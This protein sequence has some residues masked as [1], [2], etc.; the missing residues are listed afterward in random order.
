MVSVT[1][2][3]QLIISIRY[4]RRVE[5]RAQIIRSNNIPRDAREGPRA[6]PDEQPPPGRRRPDDLQGAHGAAL[7]LLPGQRVDNLA[8]HGPRH[9]VRDVA[10]GVGLSD[11]AARGVKV[12]LVGE[13][14]RR[15][16]DPGQHGEAQQREDALQQRGRAPRPGRGPLARGER[17]AGGDER[18]DVVEVVEQADPPRAVPARE[19]LGEVD[20]RGDAGNAGA[21]AEQDARD[22]EHGD[23]LR[24]GLEH[25]ADE[26]GERAPEDGGPPAEAVRHGARDERAEDAADE[27]GGRVEA[28]G[29][30]VELEVVGVGG[31]DVEAVEHGAVVA[32]GLRGFHLVLG[33]GVGEGG[34]GEALRLTEDCTAEQRMSSTESVMVD[35]GTLAGI[36]VPDG[37]S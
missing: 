29:G 11:D 19:R 34:G 16:G 26:R 31:E 17:D 9:G 25:D 7:L 33:R 30:G 20:A 12:A 2:S 27:D 35:S 22:D 37:E 6:R 5:L 10:A 36:H 13:P 1:Y 4:A 32:Y 23:V 18:A 8:V 14:A 3:F 24:G 28:G 21:E 15:L